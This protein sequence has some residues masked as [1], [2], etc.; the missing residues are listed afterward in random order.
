MKRVLFKIVAIAFIPFLACQDEVDVD[1]LLSFPPAIQES[2]P[3]DNGQVVIGGFDVRIVFADGANSPLKSASVVIKDAA[4]TE[5]ISVAED[6]TGTIDSVNIEGAEFDAASLGEGNYTMT[7]VAEDVKGQTQTFDIDFTIITSLYPANNDAMYLAGEFNGW[8]ATP[9]TLVGA[10]T[11]E[12]LNVNLGGGPFKFKN[13]P[14]WTDADWGDA[15]CDGIAAVTTGGGPNTECGYTGLVNVRFNDQTLAYTITPAVSYETNLSGLFLLGT[16]NQFS[17]PP[18][19]SFALT[20]NNTWELDEIRLK[21]G[22]AFKF[23]E[24]KTF[25]G[26]NYGDAEFDGEAEE[27]G[28]NIVVPNDYAD[29]FYKI[30]FNDETLAYTITLV[31]MPFP[32]NLYLVGGSTSIG[33]SP[34]NSI[35]FQSVGEGRFELYA[36]L[37]AA[38]G[39]FKFLQVQ[40][41]AGDWG[42][43][44]DGE[45]L[46]EGESNLEVAEDGFYRITVDF[47]NLTYSVTKT[48]WGIIGDATPGGWDA[49]TDLTYTDNYTWEGDITLGAGEWKFRANDAWDINFGDNDTNS[50]LEYGGSNIPSP[51][52]GSYHIE[53]ILAPSGYTY[54]ITPN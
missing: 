10:Y 22:D 36:P 52:A 7:V 51:G 8:G 48:S 28:P 21:A 49:D 6:L 18:D 43:G 15:D 31:R 12:A 27:F 46:Q 41:W 9:L 42:K 1:G 32:S 16:F 19:Y 23:A 35:Q 40:D 34:E 39:G 45:I 17:G 33:W 38:G 30:V 50:S 26:K 47:T 29:A 11:W 37:T 13:T 14:D 54:T 2:Y 3:F 4:G 20:A 24:T 53:L 25:Q 5:L 44:A